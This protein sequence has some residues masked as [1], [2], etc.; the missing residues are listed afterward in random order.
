[1]EHPRRFLWTVLVAIALPVPLHSADLASPT[2]DS[3]IPPTVQD[4]LSLLKRLGV[5]DWQH[6]GFRGK[7]IKIA[8]LDT[9]FRGYRDFLGKALPTNVTVKSF[10]KD[11]DLE[12]R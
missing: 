12:A 4:R 3:A 1:M 7:G 10:R 9:G 6:L 5:D 8:I 2:R 11:G